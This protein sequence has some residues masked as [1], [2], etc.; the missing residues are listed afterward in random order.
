MYKNQ[1]RRYGR[2]NNVSRLFLL[3]RSYFI[4]FVNKKYI[5]FN[6]LL[7]IFFAFVVVMCYLL[8]QNYRG[9]V[10]VVR[11]SNSFGDLRSLRVNVRMT[12][13]NEMPVRYGIAEKHKNDI[14]ITERQTL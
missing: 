5:F 13:Q 1:S 11:P 14:T 4:Y 6:I 7:I 10:V 3:F 2:K 12:I 9:V 8:Q